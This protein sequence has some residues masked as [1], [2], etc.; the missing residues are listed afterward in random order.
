MP[1]RRPYASRGV[2]RRAT[3]RRSG[4]ASA[5]VGLAALVALLRGIGAGVVWLADPFSSA[6]QLAVSQQAGGPAAVGGPDSA[7]LQ[8]GTVDSPQANAAARAL[9]TPTASPTL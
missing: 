4:K 9:A 5:G 2:P 8:M 3:T 7:V 6:K 1:A